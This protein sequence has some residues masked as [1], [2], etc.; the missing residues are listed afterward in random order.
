VNF[1]DPDGLDRNPI[2]NDLRR[3]LLDIDKNIGTFEKLRNL[4]L[5]QRLMLIY[6]FTKNGSLFD[7]KQLGHEFEDVGN[8]NYG[9]VCAAI[10][11]PDTLTYRGAGWAQIRADTS[12]SSYGSPYGFSPF[13]DDPRDQAMIQAG[14]DYYRNTYGK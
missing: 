12:S 13:G 10:N 5:G 6:K 4:P 8:F 3:Q 1:V 2:T 11:I 9:A 14:I 7:F